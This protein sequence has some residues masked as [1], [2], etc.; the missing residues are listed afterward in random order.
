MTT[1][2]SLL[3]GLNEV[4]TEKISFLCHVHHNKNPYYLCLARH[5]VIFLNKTVKR[6]EAEIF[7]AHIERI[8]V[9][10]NDKTIV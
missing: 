8:I 9:D 7:Y 5:S 4:M 2:V 10:K 3:S 1:S 6:V